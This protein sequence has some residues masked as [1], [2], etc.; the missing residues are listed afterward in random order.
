MLF[1]AQLYVGIQSVKTVYIS[2]SWA[3]SEQL[4]NGLTHLTSSRW[5]DDA[6]NKR[7]VKSRSE[8]TLSKFFTSR[9]TKETKSYLRSDARDLLERQLDVMET[10]KDMI[11]LIKT[12]ALA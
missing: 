4:Q 10:F 6:K 8:L 5:F 9:I 1:A 12:E 3:T 11:D 2:K 7:N